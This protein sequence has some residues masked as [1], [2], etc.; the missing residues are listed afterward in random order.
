MSAPLAAAPT[1]GQGRVLCP[2]VRTEDETARAAGMRQITMSRTSMVSSEHKCPGTHQLT[3]ARLRLPHRQYRKPLGVD[4][5]IP[6]LRVRAACV[7]R[8]QLRER[9]V[10]MRLPAPS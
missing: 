7:A 1:E 9:H 8:T 6:S 10:R 4:T 2:G 3:T 5:R